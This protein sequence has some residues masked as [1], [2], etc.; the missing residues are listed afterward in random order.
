[1]V[2]D[3]RNQKQRDIVEGTRSVIIKIKIQNV[4]ISFYF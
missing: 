2:L 3:G 1:M 4:Q